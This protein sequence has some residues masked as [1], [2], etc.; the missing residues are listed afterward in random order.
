MNEGKV[1]AME[2]SIQNRGKKEMGSF[3]KALVA[4]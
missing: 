2:M 1:L 4:G 3:L